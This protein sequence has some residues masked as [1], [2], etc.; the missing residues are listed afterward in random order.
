MA[1]MKTLN[2]NKRVLEDLRPGDMVNFKRSVYSHYGI[3]IDDGKIGHL[4]CD[5]T[6]Y[7]SEKADPSLIKLTHA[8]KV[9]KSTHTVAVSDFWD[10]VGDGLAFI[11]NCDDKWRPLP[12]KQIIRNVKNEQ[13]DRV[14][15][16]CNH[17][18]N[19]CRYGRETDFMTSKMYFRF[20]F[21]SIIILYTIVLISRYFDK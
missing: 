20:A 9:S 6:N 14:F 13:Y 2:H 11:V 4:C 17:F 8:N 5:H 16:N 1:A 12:V 19:V 3:Y 21:A 18:V 10:V 7:K 15:Y